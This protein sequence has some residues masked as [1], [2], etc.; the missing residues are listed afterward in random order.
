M[1]NMRT[2]EHGDLIVQFD[3]EFPPEKFFTDDIQLVKQLESVLPTKPHVDIPKGEHVEEAHMIDFHT[4]KSAHDSRGHREMY[5]AGD[6]D[7]EGS[8]HP[9]VHTCKAQ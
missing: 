5:D 8:G 4:T 1:I 6:S 7:D 2:H 9:G 3:V